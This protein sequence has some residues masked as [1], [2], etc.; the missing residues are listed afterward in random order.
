MVTGPEP[1]PAVKTV[2][3]LGLPPGIVTGEG[4]LRLPPPGPDT[5]RVTGTESPPAKPS[6]STKFPLVSNWA[7]ATVRLACPPLAI[8]NVKP[9]NRGDVPPGPMRTTPDGAIVTVPVPEA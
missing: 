9:E 6:N 7:V 2:V 1:G 8:G 4:G 5:C 3:A